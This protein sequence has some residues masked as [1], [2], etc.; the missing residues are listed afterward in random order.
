ML[1]LFNFNSQVNLQQLFALF[2]AVLSLEILKT[3]PKIKCNPK[4]LPKSP[5][6]LFMC[7]LFNLPPSNEIFNQEIIRKPPETVFKISFLISK[8][9]K[10]INSTFSIPLKFYSI[11][12]VLLG[13]MEK[14]KKL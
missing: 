11:L 2:K 6:N 12:P 8:C 5:H 3:Y 10:T 9:P 1:Y 13:I 7:R 14:L 4:K